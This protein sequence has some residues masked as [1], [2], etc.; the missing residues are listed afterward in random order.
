[1]EQNTMEQLMEFM[2][3]QFGSLECKMDSNHERM[4]AKKDAWLGKTEA[5]REATEACK[6]RT[7]ACLQEEKEPAPEEPKAVAEPGEVPERATEQETVEAAENRTGEQ[8]QAVGCRGRLKM[9][10]K[11]DGRLR[12]ECA[13]TVGRPTRHFIPALR[14]GGLWKGLGK[15]CCRSGIGGRR[16]APAPGREEWPRIMLGARNV[17]MA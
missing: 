8:R 16:K 17:T 3:A 2:K 14:K 11:C 12:Q 9:R 5:C 10:A 4:M 15:R 1:M 13:T 7:K 6:E